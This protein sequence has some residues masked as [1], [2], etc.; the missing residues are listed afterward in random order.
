MWKSKSK[1][2]GAKTLSSRVTRWRQDPILYPAGLPDGGRTQYSIQSSYLIEAGAKTLSSRVT[3]W[4]QDPILYPARVRGSGFRVW[5]YSIEIGRFY[6]PVSSIQCCHLNPTR[7]KF[8]LSNSRFKQ[9]NLKLHLSVK[10]C[11]TLSIYTILNF[12]GWMTRQIFFVADQN[13]HVFK[14]TWV[15]LQCNR[16]SKSALKSAL[17]MVKLAPSEKRF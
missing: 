5:G 17:K 8:P 13:Q 12:K 6:R 7:E 9:P 15:K 10:Y 1:L 3:R 11:N 16:H 2:A 4:R 14:P